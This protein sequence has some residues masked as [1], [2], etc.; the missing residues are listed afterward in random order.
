MA[1]GGRQMIRLIV[2][3]SCIVAGAGLVEG[4]GNFIVG[5]PLCALGAVLMLWGIANNPQLTE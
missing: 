2:G 3:L 4:S 5:V 1:R